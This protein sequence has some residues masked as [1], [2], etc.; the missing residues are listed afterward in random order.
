MGTFRPWVGVICLGLAQS[1]VYESSES[2]RVA[3]HAEALDLVSAEAPEPAPEGPPSALSGHQ[4]DT[5]LPALQPECGDPCTTGGPHWVCSDDCS[6]IMAKK[7]RYCIT[8]RWDELCVIG[9]M[10]WCGVDCGCTH[11]LSE[12]GFAQERHACDCAASVCRA[13]PSCCDDVWDNGCVEIALNP[14]QALC[15]WSD[16][17]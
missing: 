14:N 10:W 11:R 12:P 4:R 16:L 17:Y 2:E 6:K 3:E 5:T 8:T 7:D 13:Q 15:R 9:A 1:C